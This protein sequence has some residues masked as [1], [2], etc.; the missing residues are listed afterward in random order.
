MRD[1]W[2]DTAPIHSD[3]TKLDGKPWRG[4]VDLICGGFPCQDISFAGKQKGLAGERS[5][6]WSEFKRLI[7]EVRPRVVFVENVAA[8]LG[9]GIDVLLGN[10]A[11]MGY[12][13]EWRVL[14]ACIFGAPHCRERMWLV[15]HDCKERWDGG[16]V[17]GGIL[18]EKG[19]EAHMGQFRG[20]DGAAFWEKAIADFCR[21]DDGVPYRVDRLASLGNAVVPQIVEWI[22]RRIQEVS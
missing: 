4:K 5:G 10:L 3:I 6:L 8:I 1:G 21:D 13:A 20:M 17:K 15:A 2:L 7:C 22:G 12:D 9:D 19:I 11:D 18:S 14:P 16:W